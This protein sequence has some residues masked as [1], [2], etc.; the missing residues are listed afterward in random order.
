MKV[1]FL[2]F[3]SFSTVCFEKQNDDS[4]K[5]DFKKKMKKMVEMNS[6]T[7]NLIDF[8]GKEA[9]N[10]SENVTVTQMI[11][12]TAHYLNSKILNSKKLSLFLLF[13]AFSNKAQTLEERQKIVEIVCRNYLNEN[14]TLLLN[15]FISLLSEKDFN[16]IAKKQVAE[17]IYSKSKYAENSKWLAFAQIAESIPFL[18]KSVKKNPKTLRKNDL[19]ILAALAR[20]G[21][22]NAGVILC[23]YY[24]NHKNRTD[25]QYVFNAKQIAFSLDNNVL[26]CLINDYKTMDIF[27][28]F[29]D[30]DTCFIPSQVVGE[31]ITGMIKNYPYQKYNINPKQLLDWLNQNNYYELNEK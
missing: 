8:S 15:N 25:Y 6:F 28:N 18:W 22:K 29:R 24:R 30:G 19:T 4:L 1:L 2:I 16:K 23:D 12:V 31:A 9:V 20:L 13:H 3:F 10:I 27:W 21:E 26:D 11:E 14:E 7:E 5:T 17:L